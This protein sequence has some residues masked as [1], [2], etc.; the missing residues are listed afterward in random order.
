MSDLRCSRAVSLFVLFCSDTAAKKYI[1]RFA[2]KASKNG[3]HFADMHLE[4]PLSLQADGSTIYRMPYSGAFLL[5][6]STKNGT[7]HS[8]QSRTV[9]PRTSEASCRKSTH[10]ASALQIRPLLFRNYFITD[11]VMFGFFFGSSSYYVKGRW[12]GT[13]SKS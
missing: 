11:I 9:T 8:S 2:F 12:K 6:M 7:G 3:I 4:C 5:R 13:G 1:F 10:C